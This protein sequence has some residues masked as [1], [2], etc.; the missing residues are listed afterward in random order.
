MVEAAQ[1]FS[2]RSVIGDDTG[3]RNRLEYDASVHAIQPLGTAARRTVASMRF[4][5]AKLNAALTPNGT[6]HGV[7]PQMET[8]NAQLQSVTSKAKGYENQIR[9][10][11]QQL[12]GTNQRWKEEQ[13]K[14]MRVQATNTT[15]GSQMKRLEQQQRAQLVEFDA[16]LNKNERI[17][18]EAMARQLQLTKSLCDTILTT[19]DSL[20][21]DTSA[22]QLKKVRATGTSDDIDAYLTYAKNLM[23]AVSANTANVGNVANVAMKEPIGDVAMPPSTVDSIACDEPCLATPETSSSLSTPTDWMNFDSLYQT[24]QTQACA[25]KRSKMDIHYPIGCL[26][27]PALATFDTMGCDSVS[28]RALDAGNVIVDHTT[29]FTEACM[30]DFLVV[31]L[32]N[33]EAKGVPL[34]RGTTS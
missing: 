20:E 33:L 29:S 32:P 23:Q 13:T 30:K 17:S 14:T 22:V 11:E 31:M 10:L 2:L 3:V 12:R 26:S 24:M 1:N 9:L 7:G 6:S 15:L 8:L 27:V 4:D 5:T 18:D 21:I 25:R 19:T 34:H 16:R 28:S